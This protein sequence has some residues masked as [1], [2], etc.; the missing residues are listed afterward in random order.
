MLNF[1]RFLCMIVLYGY[2][3]WHLALREEYHLQVFGNKLL[4]KILGLKGVK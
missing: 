2:K 3:I 4:M 1:G